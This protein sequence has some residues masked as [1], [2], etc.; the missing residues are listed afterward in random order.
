MRRTQ[1]SP[2]G[3]AHPAVHTAGWFPGEQGPRAPAQAGPTA[4]WLRRLASVA[5]LLGVVLLAPPASAGEADPPRPIAQRLAQARQLC[6]AGRSLEADALCRACVEE[7]LAAGHREEAEDAL[8]ARIRC[9]IRLHDLVGLRD[10]SE[11]LLAVQLSGGDAQGAAQTRVD[12][13]YLEATLGSPERGILLLHQALAYYA[14]ECDDEMVAACRLRLAEAHRQRGELALALDLAEAAERAYREFGDAPGL[15]EAL[16]ALGNVADSLGRYERAAACYQ[17]EL[18]LL[19][20]APAEE[21]AAT[22]GNLGISLHEAGD[23]PGGLACVLKAREIFA[24]AGD[25]IG[26]A[27]S[28][29]WLGHFQED[30]GR[31][32]EALALQREAA[33]RGAA[34]PELVVCARID[35]ARLLLALQRHTEATAALRA[36]SALAEPYGM[37]ERMSEVLVEEAAIHLAQGNAAGAVASM[38]RAFQAMDQVVSD[39]APVTAMLGRACKQRLFEVAT[40]TALAAADDALLFE[41]VER[42]R[43]AGLRQG[44]PRDGRREADAVVP[45]ETRL[46]EKRAREAMLAARSRYEAARATHDLAQA[47]EALAVYRS[48]RLAHEAAQEAVQRARSGGRSGRAREPDPLPEVRRGLEAAQALILYVVADRDVHA[49][50]L[51]RAQS[52]RVRLG[53]TLPAST[54]ATPGGEQAPRP[55]LGTL[56]DLDFATLP[57]DQL[58]STVADLRRVLVDPLHIPSG[59]HQ[60]LISPEGAL[61]NVPFGLLVPDLETCLVPSATLH[62]DLTRRAGRAGTGTLALGDPSGTS[63]PRLPDARREVLTVTGPGDTRLL[64]ADATEAGLRDALSREERWSAVHLACHG[65]FDPR[66]PIDSALLLTPDAGDDGRLTALDVF[67][68]QVRADLVVLSAC[69]TGRGAHAAGEGLIGLSRAFLAAGASRLIVSLWPVDDEATRVF[70]ARLHAAWQEGR[71]VCEALRAAREEVAGQPRWAH[72]RFWAAWTLW[73]TP[74]CGAAR[75]SGPTGAR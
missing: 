16:R 59:I 41:L 74:S 65:V 56:A 9:L 73:G 11:Q 54:P 33:E 58:D 12:L 27:V 31:L 25:K 70:M 71:T 40:Q 46:A 57:R 32:A 17:E 72:P 30:A 42:G 18:T 53:S 3:Y 75:G 49:L 50:V 20:D 62:G 60:L 23:T 26:E 5:L 45:G 24:A 44:L 61:A 34:D 35:A 55:L 66:H 43:A 6:A 1:A 2:P 48:A 28:I 14:T 38:R 39:L 67:G 22:Y 36:A 47:R 7:A 15:A 4:R 10:A 13:G 63:R 29:A 52:W 69:D 21:V 68:L 51:T 37:R 64:G 8:F 19:A